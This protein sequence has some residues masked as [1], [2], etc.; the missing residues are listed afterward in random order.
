MEAETARNGFDHPNTAPSL[1]AIWDKFVSEK[2]RPGWRP[3]SL[4]YSSPGTYAAVKVTD[5]EQVTKNKLWLYAEE[6]GGAKSEY[7]FLMKRT[8]EGWKIDYVQIRFDD[9]RRC[10]L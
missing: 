4:S 5:A 1:L 7:R 8:A 3:V 9:W 10:G 2:P 6:K